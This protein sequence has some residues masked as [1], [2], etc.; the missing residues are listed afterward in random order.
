MAGPHGRVLVKILNDRAGEWGPSHLETLLPSGPASIDLTGTEC[1]SRTLLLVCED[2]CLSESKKKPEAYDRAA[3]LIIL[4]GGI[5]R[6]VQY[7]FNRSLW[8]DEASLALNIVSR[9]YGDLLRP[10]AYDQGAP[11]GFLFLEKLATQIV[12]PNEYGLRLVPLLGGLAAP[13]AFYGISRKYFARHTILLALCLLC[14]L[15]PF[16][17]FSTEVK[18]YSTDVLAALG[19]FW[20]ARQT[21]FKFVAGGRA[22][23]LALLGAILIWISYPAIFVLAGITCGLGLKAWLERSRTTVRAFGQRLFIYVSWSTSFL[24]FYFISIRELGS[25]ETLQESWQEKGA[26]LDADTLAAGLIWPLDRLGRFF[27]SPLGFPG[28]WDGIAIVL[29]L[30][31][32]VCLYRR[33]RNELLVFL[34]P[35]VLTLFA[36][37]IQ[38]Y[39]FHG[40]LVLFLSPF[41]IW[42]MAA[43]ASGLMEAKN[44]YIKG[45]GI[46]LSTLLVLQTLQKTAPLFYTPNLREEIRPVI[47]HVRARSQANDRLYIFQRGRLQFLFYAERYGYE[48]DDY[49]LGIDDLDDL[50]GTG[51]SE[52]ERRRYY[53]DL[54]QLRGNPRVWVLFS[55]AWVT[56]ENELVAN[57]LDCW[58]R[59]LESFQAA[60][61]FVYL[62]DMSQSDSACLP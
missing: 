20:V 2:T 40:R 12:A 53:R 33:Q 46:I 36:A 31:G 26:F 17:Y 37:C 35:I 15:Y 58:G 32:C 44:I 6:I 34:F 49:I 42:P 56:E 11:V 18:Q 8:A 27:Y 51:V 13:I 1:W 16:V 24:L 25:N 60:G 57:Y 23:L 28:P 59:R 14:F 10:L 47:E 48:P 7:L 30:V 55:H 41:F 19:C 62:Y 39:P 29:F 5:V 43:G 54:A 22:V 50:D 3:W 61:A 4:G 52:R 9:S 21:E 38:S 45:I